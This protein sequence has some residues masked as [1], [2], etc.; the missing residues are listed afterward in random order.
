MMDKSDKLKKKPGDGAPRP[1]G[2]NI[3]T[4]SALFSV[5]AF[6]QKVYLYIRS[7]FSLYFVVVDKD[8]ELLEHN[9][10]DSISLKR[11]SWIRRDPNLSQTGTGT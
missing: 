7:S 11:L 3:S 1:R 8:E 2:V 4:S 5:S 9:M 10:T 6:L